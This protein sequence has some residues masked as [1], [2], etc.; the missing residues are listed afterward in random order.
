MQ[1][2]GPGASLLQ[3]VL[4]GVQQGA[5]RTAVSV[6]EMEGK[7][8]LDASLGTSPHQEVSEL[9]CPSRKQQTQKYPQIQIV[10]V[11]GGSAAH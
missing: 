3:L 8:G 6:L 1:D 7:Q 4:V 9:N 5:H 2:A 11:P 10:P